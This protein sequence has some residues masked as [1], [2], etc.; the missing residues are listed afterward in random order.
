M[1]IHHLAAHMY[2]IPVPFQTCSSGTGADRRTG[3]AL[4]ILSSG[5][6]RRCVV[7][8]T[9]HSLYPRERDPVY[10]AKFL[11]KSGKFYHSTKCYMQNILQCILDHVKFSRQFS[12]LLG[13]S[14]CCTQ[15]VLSP[16]SAHSLCIIVKPD[17]RVTTSWHCQ[18]ELAK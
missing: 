15:L 2:P 18:C 14:C 1:F 10:I 13:T 17:L 12:I 11:E 7:S 4:P 8:A 6:R 16:Y 9:P 3:I 5:S